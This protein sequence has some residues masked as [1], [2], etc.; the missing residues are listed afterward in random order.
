MENNKP[1][2]VLHS[3][4]V[5]NRGGAETLIMNIYRNIDRSKVQFDFL[6]HHN[7]EGAYD[8]EIR[9]LGGRIYNV[10]YGVRTLHFGYV[11]ALNKFFNEHKEYNVVHSH[12]SDASGIIAEV[13]RKNNVKTRIAHSHIANPKHS[14]LQKIYL[15]GYAKS[16]IPNNCNYY[17]AC[18][19]E[20]GRYLFSN[21]RIINKF[22]VIKNSIDIDKY[23]PNYEVRSEVRKKLNIEND[24]VLGH[25]GRFQ[26]QKNH[27]FL[28]DIFYEV[29]KRK[30]NA[31]LLLVGGGALG[32]E[33]TKNKVKERIREKRIVDKV[34]FLGVRSDV[35]RLMQAFDVFVF[36]SL[37]E[38]LPLTLIEA[39]TV[40]I[41]CAIS[42][43]ITKD[44]DLGLG[45]LE[46]ISLDNI[47]EWVEKIITLEKK[48]VINKEKCRKTVENN[49]Y[50]IKKVA[51]YLEEFYIKNND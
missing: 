20:A 18:S 23:L 51:K 37:Y 50:D 14:F 29:L 6:T 19:K 35:N 34:V 15:Q 27:L 32:D 8:K 12:M 36:P 39:Q 22:E 26:E 42:D 38:G 40:G 44:V 21:K 2:R 47:N 28:I 7:I 46:F 30:P 24:F 48:R 25:V 45:N 9:S 43:T 3:V 17:F 5:M 10:P 41:G 31:K 11:H 1:I 49:G 13:A 33:G 4:G 16:L